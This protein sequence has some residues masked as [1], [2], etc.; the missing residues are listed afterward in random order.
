MD[1]KPA[2]SDSAGGH[3]TTRH[4]WLGWTLALLAVPLV[5]VLTM[6]A[7]FYTAIPD[8]LYDTSIPRHGWA[9]DY[10]RPYAWMQEEVPFLNRPLKNYAHWWLIKL[11][12]R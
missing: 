11:Q 8:G 6:P 7:I 10:A 1:S 3:P 9:M 2:H 4:A 5:Y 12:T